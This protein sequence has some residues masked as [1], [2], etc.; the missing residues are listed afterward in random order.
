MKTQ[1]ERR[2][3]FQSS[4]TKLLG[5]REREKTTKI[6]R[7]K[8]LFVVWTRESVSLCFLVDVERG[9]S[10]SFFY[11]FILLSGSGEGNRSFFK[12]NL[13]HLLHDIW[14]FTL[15]LFLCLSVCVSLMLDIEFHS[16]QYLDSMLL[17][18]DARGNSYLM[19]W[20]SMSCCRDIFLSCLWFTVSRII[21]L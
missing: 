4:A 8:E 17:G 14:L 3:G 6:E 2:K 5:K 1:T 13:S 7:E 16:R 12:T 10:C 15:P 11:F 20:R 19:G 18:V 21:S 9:F